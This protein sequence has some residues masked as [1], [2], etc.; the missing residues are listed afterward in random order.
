ML[1]GQFMIPPLR[2]VFLGRPLLLSSDEAR[3]RTRPG[4][5]E[6]VDGFPLEFT[7]VSR[8]SSFLRI[9]MHLVEGSVRDIRVYQA[10]Q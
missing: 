2:F 10:T 8:F 7:G 3:C 4:R 1:H 6:R 9:H 5:I